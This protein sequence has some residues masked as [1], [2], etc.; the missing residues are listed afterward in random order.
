MLVPY[1]PRLLQNKY[2]SSGYKLFKAGTS[3]SFYLPTREDII[4]TKKNRAT[5]RYF[6]D[7]KVKMTLHGDH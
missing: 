2:L 1:C 6:E 3:K 4:Y 7:Y 5:I